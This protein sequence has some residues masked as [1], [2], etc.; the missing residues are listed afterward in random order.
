MSNDYIP[1]TD[2]GFLAWV[3]NLFAYVILHASA[4]NLNPA[5]WSDIDPSM[6]TAYESALTKAQDPN[7]G[8]ADVL[9]K[10]TTR[11]T[12]KSATRIF[13]KAQLEYNPAVTDEDRRRMGLPVHDAKPTPVADPSTLALAAIKLPSPGVVE[14]SVVDSASRRK[15]KPAGI[16]GF[17]FAWAILETPPADWEQL[18]HSSFSTKT[19]FRLS[20]SGH[21]R[22]K[23]LYFATRWENT[24]G[25]KGPWSE[26]D[27][28]IIS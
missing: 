15:A 28:T 25:V 7:R 1:A 19:S 27:S 16:H 21:D 17:E 4:W 6:I 3:K 2:T 24:K 11:N 26:I 12:L 20:F 22:G 18:S 5:S 9:A 8:K 13:V 14:V 23:T 10:N